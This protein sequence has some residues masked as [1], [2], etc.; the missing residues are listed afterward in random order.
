MP[1]KLKNRKKSPNRRCFK[2]A[3]LGQKNC[4]KNAKSPQVEALIAGE[5]S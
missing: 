5:I 1:E 3:F 4:Q 2:I